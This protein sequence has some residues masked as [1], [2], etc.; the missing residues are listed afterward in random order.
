MWNSSLGA[1]RRLNF[2]RQG[3]TIDVLDYP[4][5]RRSLYRPRNQ[6]IP[7]GRV[8]IARF[9]SAR[10]STSA[11]SRGCRPN[12]LA[13]ASRERRAGSCRIILDLYPAAGEHAKT[14]EVIQCYW[15]SFEPV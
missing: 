14:S 7:A 11:T 4:S 2:Q 12:F 6:R 3:E 9:A 5:A 13:R 15:L 1:V 8:L 10:R